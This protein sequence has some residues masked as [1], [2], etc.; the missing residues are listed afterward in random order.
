MT[1]QEIKDNMSK[2]EWEQAPRDVEPIQFESEFSGTVTYTNCDVI[3]SAKILATV[4][5][6]HVSKGEQF[7]VDNQTEYEANAQAITTAVN[8]SYGAGLDPVYYKEIHE[9]LTALLIDC[10]VGHIP[11]ANTLHDIKNILSKAKLK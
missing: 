10:N 11:H 2:G 3:A 1:A 4:K 9:W 5:L 6:T 8:S 7:Y